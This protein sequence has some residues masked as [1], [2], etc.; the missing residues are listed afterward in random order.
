MLVEH[1]SDLQVG[2]SGW[3]SRGA[4]LRAYKKQQAE[5]SAKSNL[6]S[7]IAEFQAQGGSNR[8]ESRLPSN[9]DNPYCGSYLQRALRAQQPEEAAQVEKQS[10]I[11]ALSPEE[12]RTAKDAWEWYFYPH[13]LSDDRRKWAMKFA[14]ALRLAL[15]QETYSGLDDVRRSLIIRLIESEDAVKR[16]S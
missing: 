9:L 14:A 6:E 10:L 2:E 13:T 11:P 16:F 5:L 3:N 12:F 7:K 1:P 15:P 8:S 4:Y